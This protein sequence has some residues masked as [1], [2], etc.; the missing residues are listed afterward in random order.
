MKWLKVVIS[1]KW[2][3]CDCSVTQVFSRNNWFEWSGY[4]F[5][6][7]RKEGRK[8]IYI[9]KVNIVQSWCQS[10]KILFIHALS[11]P[12]CVARKIKMFSVSLVLTRKS[13][14][15]VLII[16]FFLV[17]FHLTSNNNAMQNKKISLSDYR[18]SK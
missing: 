9:D 7:Q 17:I 8:E 15:L 11:P 6:V 3:I 10:W 5:V 2:F 14:T 1:V 13:F 16:I 12:F 18:Q 4:S